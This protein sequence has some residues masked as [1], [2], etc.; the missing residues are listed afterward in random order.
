MKTLHPLKATLLATAIAMG[1]GAGSAVAHERT[2]AQT[3][4]DASISASVKAAL[5]ADARTKGLAIDVDTVG[6]VVTL[7]GGADTP[8]TR[9]A[10]TVIASSVAGVVSIDNR[11]TLVGEAPAVSDLDGDGV[12][13]VG[14]GPDAELNNVSDLD[15]DGV[16]EVGPGPD[17]ELDNVSDLDNDG[18]DEVGPGPDANVNNVSDLDGDGVDEVGPGPDAELNNVSDLDGDGVDEVGPGPDAPVND[19]VGAPVVDADDVDTDGQAVVDNDADLDTDVDADAAADGSADL[20]AGTGLGSSAAAHASGNATT[21]AEGDGLVSDAT[22]RTLQDTDGDGIDEVG[23]GPDAPVNNVGE[24]A[25]TA[26]VKSKLLADPT[27]SGLAIDVDTRGDVVTLTGKVATAAQRD[28]AVRLAA[29]TPGVRLVV[30]GGL[31]VGR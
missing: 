26:S 2:A 8:A 4:Q 19:T 15:D 7:S 29:A 30:A 23:P 9:D 31:T 22:P 1:F 13:E 14:P 10:A 28:A 21:T 6:G 3:V 16:D 18:V 24:A 12:D 20:N 25:I 27:V 17:A 11:L 5:L